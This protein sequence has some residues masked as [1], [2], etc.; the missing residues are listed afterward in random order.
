MNVS[1]SVNYFFKI[2]FNLI[3]VAVNK[4]SHI[5]NN[6]NMNQCIDVKLRGLI[7]LVKGK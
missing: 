2:Y 5:L 6:Q 4:K 7:S 3:H 1:A